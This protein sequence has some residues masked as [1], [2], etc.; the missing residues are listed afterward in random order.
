MGL[1]ECQAKATAD[2]KAKKRADAAA[3]G[4][5]PE[6]DGEDDEEVKGIQWNLR[7]SAKMLEEF[8]TTEGEL[9]PEVIPT[10]KGFLRLFAAW[11]IDESL[12]WTTGEAPGLRA[13]FTYLKVN[14]Y[15][16]SDTTVRN[17][18]A[19]IFAELH[20]KVVRENVTRALNPK[21]PIPPTPGPTS[22]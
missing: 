7:A 3:A 20:E 12:P 2:E 15:L 10:Q 22:R 18:L 1:S 4:K 21:S 17:H 8:L 11:I 14:F 6:H 9:N 13:L 16:P 19:H 5:A